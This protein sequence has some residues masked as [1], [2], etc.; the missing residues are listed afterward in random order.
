MRNL[1]HYPAKSI[2]PPTISIVTI[3]EYWFHSANLGM[4]SI[5]LLAD[6]IN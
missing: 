3:K 4:D 6:L 5:A 1:G 2:T